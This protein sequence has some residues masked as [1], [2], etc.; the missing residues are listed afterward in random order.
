MD[1]MPAPARAIL[2][3]LLLLSAVLLLQTVFW[4]CGRAD[5]GFVKFERDAARPV[6]LAPDARTRD[7]EERR[8]AVAAG[9]EGARSRPAADEPEPA[10]NPVHAEVVAWDTLP[11][12]A[13]AGRIEGRR[14]PTWTGWRVYA[15]TRGGPGRAFSRSEGAD[16]D[17]ATGAFRIEGLPRGPTEVHWYQPGVGRGVVTTVE[18]DGTGARVDLAY[19]GPDPVTSIFVEVRGELELDPTA[20]TAR[21][22]GGGGE[23]WAEA[24][25][26]TNRFA[27]PDLPHGRYVVDVEVP[28]HEPWS[29]VASPGERLRVDLVPVE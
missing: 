20:V 21:L 15:T 13:I 8:T 12:G 16:V 7:G 24:L 10:G 17:A 1:G 19:D 3:V 28:G 18:L 4:D 11:G 14:V 27:V 25:S 9:L 2:S 23:L 22:E 6:A 29:E 5:A 26:G